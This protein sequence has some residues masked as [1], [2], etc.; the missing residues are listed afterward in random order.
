MP[1]QSLF[2]EIQFTFRHSTPQEPLPIWLASRDLEIEHLSC[3]PVPQHGAEARL[4]TEVVHDSYYQPLG[5][6]DIR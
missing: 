1:I 4:A 5:P 6:D 2:C 3:E